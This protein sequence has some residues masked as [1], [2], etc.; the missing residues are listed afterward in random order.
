M[1]NVK[2]LSVKRRRLVEAY[3]ANGFNGK[4]AAITAGFS[5]KR[6]AATASEILA[7][8]LVRAYIDERMKQAQM[9][10]DE[11]L[12]RL[13]EMA[14]GDMRE[15][16]M[17]SPEELKRHPKAWLIKKIKFDVILPKAEKKSAVPD[18]ESESDGGEEGFDNETGKPFVYIDSVELYDAQAALVMI[19]KHH[20]LFT[21]KQ[22]ITGED[23]KPIP[24]LITGMDMS[25][26]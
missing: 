11:V 20:K 8:P 18:E 21:D 6:A 17:L 2:K 24:I 23:G 1:A 25:E 4:E 16:M 19:G 15:L 14:R 5:V 26:L 9:S 22:E 13:G 12:Y 10:A 3:L 7:D